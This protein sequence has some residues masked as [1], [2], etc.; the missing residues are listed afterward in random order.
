M[1]KNI[2]Y[3][4]F[5]C[6]NFTGQKIQHFYTLTTKFRKSSL[7]L[8][9]F[10]SRSYLHNLLFIDPFSTGNFSEAD[11]SKMPQIPVKIFRCYHFK[12]N[13][14]IEDSDVT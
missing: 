7:F 10:Q 12:S 8:N 9:S 11:F 6:F 14:Q 1:V 13:I 3:K 2:L 4:K 5:S